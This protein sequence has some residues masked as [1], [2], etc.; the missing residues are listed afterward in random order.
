MMRK[1]VKIK[2]LGTVVTGTTPPTK[3]QEYYGQEY[4]FI[5]PTYIDLDSR[6]FEKSEIK[7]SQEAY[8]KYENTFI[9]PYSTSVVTIGSIGE[10][11]CMNRELALTNQQINSVI[12]NP[13]EYDN[14]FVFYLLKHN[15]YKVK[16]ANS[17][18]SS[19]REN[20]N[21]STFSNIEVEVPDL[22][23]QK[24]I[25]KILS[26]YDDLIENNLKRIKLLEESAELIYK[27]W[28]VN[29]KFPGYEK[30]N[31]VDG[32]PEG[33]SKISVKDIAIIQGGYAFKSK[34]WQENG[35]PVIKIKNITDNS[36]DIV[37]CECISDEVADKVK[38]YKLNKGDLLI[39]MTGATVGKIGIMPRSNKNYYLN[40][41]VARIMS[42]YKYDISSYLF[43]IFNS[44]ITKQHILNLAKGS[45]QPNI[46]A[47]DIGSINT[48]LP[49][50][51]IMIQYVN[52][53]DGLLNKR[54][55]LIEHNEKLKEARDILIPR[56]ISGEIEV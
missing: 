46:S 17:G 38:S 49:S 47:G 12:P 48:L 51:D 4:N 8:E 16:A 52:V 41:R 25:G 14:M 54:L 45:A 35:N 26:S 43:S 31:I 9:P 39:A 29:L 6:F 13:D 1:T 32:T 21:K 20:V 3:M 37:N 42:N 19:G 22:S 40:Q 55:V 36:I 56:L 10:K 2:D 18:S 7:L 11:I 50:D 33:W 34:E 53:V 30:Y 24:K 23:T 44:D 27:E 28:F 5:K 15:L